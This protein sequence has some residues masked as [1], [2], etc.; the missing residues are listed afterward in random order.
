MKPDRVYQAEA[1]V[2]RQFK[3]GEADK[4]L[5]LY[6]REYGKIRAVAKGVRKPSSR[7]SGHLDLLTA[8]QIQLAHGRT[9]DII[10]QAQASDMFLN[11][12][13][14]LDRLSRGLYVAELL[15]AFTD[16][17]MAASAL[18]DL[19]LGTLQRLSEDEPPAV[20][21]RYFELQLVHLLGWR[22]ELHRCPACAATL[23]AEAGFFHGA[24]GG[25]VCPDCARSRSGMQRISLPAFK[26]LRLWQDSPWETARR[27]RLEPDLDDELE[28][29]LRHYLRHLLERDL[30]SADFLDHVRWQL[31]RPTEPTPNPDQESQ[32]G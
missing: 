10:T 11:L 8:V 29:L 23:Q 18:Y 2:L 24:S 26:V 22:P 7:K 9:F 12:K 17:R 20:S 30:K 4:V 27:V 16:E 15:D 31:A 19:T 21:L 6:T 5:T 32:P 14:D 25:V 1:I 3:L 28:R 13:S